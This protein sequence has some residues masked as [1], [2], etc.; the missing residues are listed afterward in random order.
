MFTKWIKIKALVFSHLFLAF[1]PAHANL[2]VFAC[3]PEWSALVKALGGDHVTVYAATTNKQDP[4]HIQARPSLIAKARRADLL[5]CTGAEL[6]IG[7]LPL[8]L[9]KSG[10]ARIQAGQSGHFMAADY[11][12]LIE[13]PVVLDR[14]QGDIHAAGN[15]H[16]HLD[17]TRV[18]QVAE[19]L[20]QTLVQIDPAHQV[21]YRNQLALFTQ[22]W[23]KNLGQWKMQTQPI[24]GKSIV[25]HHNSWVYLQQWLG[26][27]QVGTLELKPGVPPTSSN[28]SQML[29]N[30]EQI[31][32]YGIIYA[33]YQDDKAANWLSQKTGIPI[34]ALDSGPAENETLVQWFDRLIGKL[35]MAHS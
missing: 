2:Q 20:S 19:H 6:E 32:V 21:D 24:R 11:V 4:H 12:T 31:S 18:L 1:N 33:S 35:L 9:R 34:V 16:I 27:K 10:N 17:P 3:E 15:P 28:L 25:V 30:L 23:Q 14:S 7:W 13:K 22:E 26:L 29:S 8:L 5:V